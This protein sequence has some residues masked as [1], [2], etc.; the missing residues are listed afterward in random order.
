MGGFSMARPRLGHVLLVAPLV[1][2]AAWV[3]LRAGTSS[4]DPG[5]VLAALRAAQGP[6]LPAAAA[7][8]AVRCSEP[9][10]YDRDTLY[11]YIDGAA[12]G[13]LS[14]GFERCV[15]ATFT[16]A[17]APALEVAA[18][19]HR[20]AAPEGARAQLEAERP[21]SARAVA[22]LAETWAD[23]TTLVAVHGRDYLKLTALSPGDAAAAALVRFAAAWSETQ[24]R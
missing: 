5:A 17:G 21:E 9:A 1:A 12:E 16:F 3:A 19:A 7:A 6:R 11:Q 2:V 18:E 23:G 4:Q 20:F 14:H 10:S 8:G 15:A 22:G 24:P 13:Y